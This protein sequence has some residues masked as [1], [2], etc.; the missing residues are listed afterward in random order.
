MDIDRQLGVFPIHENTKSYQ[1]RAMET[2]TLTDTFAGEQVL[3]TELAKI[4][5]N[6]AD[7]GWRQAYLVARLMVELGQG[8]EDVGYVAL[9][10][11]DVEKTLQD[12]EKILN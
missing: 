4:A 8:I 2:K 3:I 5:Q 12:V 11:Q 1:R 10:I 7:D 9:A 6:Y